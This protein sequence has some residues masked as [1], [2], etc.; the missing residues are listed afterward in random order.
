ML[1]ILSD[2]HF[3]D[4]TAGEH[5]L[6]PEA[7]ESVLLTDLAAIIKDKKIEQVKL[8]WRNSLRPHNTLLI[9]IGLHNRTHDTPK[10]DTIATHLHGLRVSCF[11]F[12][13]DAKC[14]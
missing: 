14:A 10:S 12:V 3:V 7:F 4:E 6:P 11:V 1:V 9:S 13:C 5:N 2:L 8:E